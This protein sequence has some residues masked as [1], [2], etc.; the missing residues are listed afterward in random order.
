MWQALRGVKM[1]RRGRQ[2]HRAQGAFFYGDLWQFLYDGL[3]S[4]TVTFG[5]AIQDLGEDVT[6]PTIDGESFDLV[7]LADGGWSKL[8]RYVTNAQPQYAGYVCWR[9][10]IDAADYPSGFDDFGMYK[11]GI[12]DTMM[13]PCCKDDGTDMLGGGV[14]I[15]TPPDEV[16]RPRDGASRHISA[17]ERTTNMASANGPA[18]VPEWLLPLYTQ[19]FGAH[20]NGELVRLFEAFATKGSLVPH[21]QY[22]YVADRISA[23]R[24]VLVGDAAH[25]ASPRTAAGAHTAVLDALAMREEFARGGT[26]DDAIRRYSSTALERARRLHVRSLDV[27]RQ[28]LPA[29]GIS[30]VRSPSQLVAVAAA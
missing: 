15:A 3:P 24:V 16:V 8:R 28:F 20:A 25:M 17:D 23:G 14:F 12:L 13:L 18:A 5:R 1:L 22:D 4:G 9:G 7:V 26:V 2:A 10:Q 30:A 11:S 27:R 6:K 19:H 21:P 29:G